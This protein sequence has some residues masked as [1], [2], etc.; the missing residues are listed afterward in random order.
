MVLENTI[1]FCLRYKKL[2]PYQISPRA[3]ERLQYSIGP[4][5]GKLSKEYTMLFYHY[6]NISLFRSST[7]DSIH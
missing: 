7:D 2:P 6:Q 3:I 1:L 5:M 4:R